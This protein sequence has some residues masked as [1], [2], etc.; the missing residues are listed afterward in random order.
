MN[1]SSLEK[2]DL[3]ST[4]YSTVHRPLYYY[5][6]GTVPVLGVEND[7]DGL[8]MMMIVRLHDL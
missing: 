8:M 1:Q 6:P 2:T 3:Y 7:D 5:V 4:E